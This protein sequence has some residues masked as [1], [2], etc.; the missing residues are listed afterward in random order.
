MRNLKLYSGKKKKKSEA[1]GKLEKGIFVG[2][3]EAKS[4]KKHTVLFTNVLLIF[5]LCPFMKLT[6]YRNFNGTFC[7]EG[8]EKSF[9][10][11]LVD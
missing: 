2:G 3:W 4:C 10:F 8:R 5:A 6:G 7:L 1:F 9:K 11:Y